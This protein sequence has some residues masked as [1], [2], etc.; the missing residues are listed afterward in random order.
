[1]GAMVSLA[2]IAVVTKIDLISQ[3]EREVLIQ[4][5]RSSSQDYSSRNKRPA[6]HITPTSL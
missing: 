3:A 4:K 5:I 2:D 1:M 6:R